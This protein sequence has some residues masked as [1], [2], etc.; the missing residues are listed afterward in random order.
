MCL[1]GS[2]V[3]EK[4]ITLGCWFVWGFFLSFLRKK[5][6]AY[7]LINVNQVFIL[8]LSPFTLQR[9]LWCGWIRVSKQSQLNVTQGSS[10]P[11]VTEI[12]CNKFLLQ[13]PHLDCYTMSSIKEKLGCDRESLIGLAVLLGCDYLPKVSNTIIF[14]YVLTLSWK[15]TKYIKGDVHAG[16]AVC[17]AW[18]LRS[19]RICVVSRCKFYLLKAKDIENGSWTSV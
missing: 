17:S 8:V 15:T 10:F 16:K 1:S 14:Y 18:L 11:D 19:S 3:L 13:D 9:F 12:M 7:V 5:A 6:V 4:W 2:S